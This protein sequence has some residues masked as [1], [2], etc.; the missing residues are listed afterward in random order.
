MLHQPD[1]AIF[2]QYQLYIGPEVVGGLSISL[3]I[4]FA[5]VAGGIFTWLGPTVGAVITLVLSEG[6]RVAIGTAMV[7]LDT[8]IYGVMLVLFIIFMPKGIV[9]ELEDRWG[10]NRV[11]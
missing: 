10:N 2:G 6:L 5:V 7:G 9:G 11:A 1:G 4:V 8:A 3:Q